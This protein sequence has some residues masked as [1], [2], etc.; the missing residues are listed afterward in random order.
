M[1]R[2]KIFDTT[3]RDGEQSPGCT[4]NLK[5]KIEIARCLEKLKVDVI[6]AGFAISSP[7]DFE[8]VNTI[9]KHIRECEIA[10]LARS[11]EKDIDTAWEAVK[12]AENPRIHLFIATSKL[13]MDYKLKMTEEE[14]LERIKYMTA[15]AKKYCSN[16]EFSAEDATRSDLDFLAK[17][18]EIAIANGATVVNLPDTV[19]YSTPDEMKRMISYVLEHAEGAEDIE[20]S[21]HCHNDLGMATANSLA[22][23]AA[24]ARQI[25][26]T[27]NGLGE[28]AGNT[29]LEEVV[30]AM[31]TR[32]DFFTEVDCNIDTTQIYRASKTVYNVI[33]Q[34]A[35]LNK[36]VVGQNAFAHESGIHQHGVQANKLTYEIMT[37]ELIGIHTNNIVLGKHSG[38]HAFQ[39]H[40]ESMGYQL[41]EE[42]LLKSFDAF[43]ALCD[44]KKNVNDD[45]IEAI[46]LSNTGAEV[47]VNEDDYYKL[48][49]FAVHTSNFTTSTSTVCLRR[50]EEKFEQVALGDGPIDASFAAIDQ[51]MNPEEHTFGKFSIHSIS[52]GKDTLGSVSV[53][54]EN[55]DGKRFIGRGLSTDI[56]EAGI[57]AYL[58]A[59]NKMIAADKRVK[60]SAQE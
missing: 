17:A 27:I 59:A 54:L 46:I 35:P 41:S 60:I 25:E 9:A 11:T 22:G 21:V 37:P 36:S 1:R 12:V 20:L 10:S 31:K 29:A 50:G 39:E 3:L 38:K 33:G 40:I 42:E 7:G 55:A 32:A 15:Y 26:C 53:T 23:V 52:E 5:E 44:K 45:D 18:T 4:M 28:R 58:G 48:D 49:W 6:E 16:I 30:M 56:I 57:Q 8:S 34:H 51:I 43:K 47:E 19:G 2:I 13:H 24:G 14:V